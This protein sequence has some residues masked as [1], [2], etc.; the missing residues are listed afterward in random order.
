MRTK[1]KTHTTN[2]NNKKNLPLVAHNTTR[3]NCPIAAN[4]NECR[5]FIM[6]QKNPTY[7]RPRDSL[8]SQFL[9]K[10]EKKYTVGVATDLPIAGVCRADLDTLHE[11]FIAAKP[12]YSTHRS[13]SRPRVFIHN[14]F[15]F[16]GVVAYVRTRN[17]TLQHT[18]CN[19][20]SPFCNKPAP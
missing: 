2:D 18:K 14:A 5:C 13:L 9:A 8:I 6:D 17:S 4:C 16:V 11:Y 12:P 19:K 20:T 15:G 3:R 1:I 7:G 10:S